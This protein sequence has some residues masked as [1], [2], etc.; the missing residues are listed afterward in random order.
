MNERNR[1]KIAFKS[2]KMRFEKEIG[3]KY[4]QV[5]KFKMFVSSKLAHV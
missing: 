4:L 2:G 3:K 5:N 1:R